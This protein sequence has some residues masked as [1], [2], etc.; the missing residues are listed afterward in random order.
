[1]AFMISYLEINFV[2]CFF[3]CRSVRAVE[4]HCVA[5]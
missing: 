4:W 2:I 1:M 3:Y 5:E